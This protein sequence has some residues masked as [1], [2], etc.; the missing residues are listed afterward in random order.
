MPDGFLIRVAKLSDV[1]ISS[2][3]CAAMFEAMGS[4]TSDAVAPLV[5]ETEQFLRQAIPG[6]EHG[7]WLA[8]LAASLE[9]VISGVG[10]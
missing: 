3:Y 7:G 1:P 6:G 9:Q 4:T 5:A 10:V 8:A 2:H